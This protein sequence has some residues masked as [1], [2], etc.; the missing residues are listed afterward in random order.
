MNFIRC[1][2]YT[3]TDGQK[4]QILKEFLFGKY[5]FQ[6]II[7]SYS[8]L[9]FRNTNMQTLKYLIW[10]EYKILLDCKNDSSKRRR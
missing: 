3:Q 5:T 6:K 1:E 7:F 4:L 10:V 2:I 9:K 8:M